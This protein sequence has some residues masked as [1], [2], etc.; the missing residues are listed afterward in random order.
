MGGGSYLQWAE[1]EQLRSNIQSVVDG[2]ASLREPNGWTYAFNESDIDSNNNPD[3][4]AAWLTRG[5]LDAHRAGIFGAGELNRAAISLFNNHSRLAW[6]LPP[7]GGPEPSLPYPSGFDNVTD[8]GFGNGPGH[9]IY[10]QFQGMIKHSLTALDDDG[11]QADI[12]ILESLY[13]EQWWLHA[14]LN[15]DTYHAIWHRQFFSHKYEVT[16]FEA[17]LD[18]Y[19]LTGNR[20]YY[21][22]VINAWHMLRQGWMLP[23]GSLALNEGPYYPPGSYFIGFTG[24]AVGLVDEEERSSEREEVERAG[25]GDDPYFH[26]KCM[27][28]PGSGGSSSSYRSPLQQLRSAAERGRPHSSLPNA[29]DPP[30]GELCGSVFWTFLNKRL[31]QLQP[32]EEYAAEMERSIINVGIS[33]LGPPG[34]GGEGPNGT[35]IR[36]FANQHKQKQN[37]SMHAS[38]CEGQGSRLFGSLPKFL[39]SLQGD[40][41]DT[42]AVYVDIYAASLLTIRVHGQ[43]ATLEV[44]TAW[45]YAAQVIVTLTLLSASSSLLLILRMPAWLADFV[46]I[47]VN[48]Q[49]C[50]STGVPGAFLSTRMMHRGSDVLLFALR[51][52]VYVCFRQL[53]QRDSSIWLGGR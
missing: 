53:H 12:D 18:L 3:Y 49:V 36:Y 38:C 7:N 4:C 32:R 17:I 9:M 2:I 39:Y 23:G 24:T 37:P 26:S 43:T 27:F 28:H 6:F 15:N 16:A 47:T 35:G 46:P 19:V 48:G 34:S 51:I 22:A 8:G 1:D 33:A 31:H 13:L 11:A 41:N 25:G 20:T 30:T 42:R 52:P 14:L 45:P 50:P 44:D 40:D 29:N 5:L 10:I 21:Q